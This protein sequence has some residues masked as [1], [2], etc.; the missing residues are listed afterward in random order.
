MSRLCVSLGRIDG[1]ASWRRAIPRRRRGEVTRRYLAAYGPATCERYGRWAGL[2]AAEAGRRLDAIADERV[3]VEVE[4]ERTWMLAEHVD[5]A[6][7]VSPPRAVRLLP[8]FDPYIMGTPRDEP[9]IVPVGFK[10]R[11]YRGSGWI[12]AVLLVDGGVAG[13]W[14][15]DQADGTLKLQI[16]TFADVPTWARKAAEAEAGALAECARSFWSSA[17][18]S[19]RPER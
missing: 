3:Q 2:G 18:A 15:Y 12:S 11:V 5:E 10:D 8:R 13:A 16:E 1:W 7:N 19:R 4:G 9:G 6:A 14:E 17:G